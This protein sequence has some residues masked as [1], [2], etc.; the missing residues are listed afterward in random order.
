MNLPH[1][2]I[3]PEGYKV[4]ILPDDELKLKDGVIFIPE[5]IKDSRAMQTTKATV[6][7]VGPSV[8]LKIRDNDETRN[9]VPGDRVIFRR[10]S[11]LYLEEGGDYIE[12]RDESTG[13]IKSRERSERVQFRIVNDE[14]IIAFIGSANVESSEVR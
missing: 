12:E 7:K 8:D 2:S 11:G 13:Q 14:D 6:V 3:E 4:L 9:I 1:T 5:H 10:W